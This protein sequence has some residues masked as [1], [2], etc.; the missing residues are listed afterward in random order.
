MNEDVLKKV[1]ARNGQI[2]QMI[3]AME[4]MS[5]LTKELSKNIRGFENRDAILEEVA[6]VYIMLM[7]IEIIHRINTSELFSRIQKKIERLERR[8]EG[9]EDESI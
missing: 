4:E 3:I 1:I 8:L 7:Q 9:L 5:E 2:F 6:D